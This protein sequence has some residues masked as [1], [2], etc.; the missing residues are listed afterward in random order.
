MTVDREVETAV[1]RALL[2]AE[3][4]EATLTSPESE[5]LDAHHYDRWAIARA[6]HIDNTK[7]HVD[8]QLASLQLSRNARIAQL[9]DQ[10][11]AAH[12]PNIVRM[13]EGELRAVEYD[14]AQRSELLQRA[15]ERSDITTTML[16]RGVLEVL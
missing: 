16:Y 2:V 1:E 3:P 7:V 10:L 8:A 11:A 5:L 14:F 15:V 9:E 12:H 6:D 13:R 4:G